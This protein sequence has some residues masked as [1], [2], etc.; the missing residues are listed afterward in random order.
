[1]LLGG[2]EWKDASAEADTWWLSRSSR[3]VVTVITSAAPDIPDTQVAWAADHFRELGAKVEGCQ[4]QSRRDA[5]DTHLLEQLAQAAA[6]YLCGGDPG[7]AQQALWDTPAAT[8]LLAAYRSGV[9]L[10]GSSA[11][12]MVLGAVCLVPGQDF[13]TRPGLGVFAAAV[14]PHWRGA[15]RRWRETAHRLSEDGE[16][17]AVDEST[18]ACWDGRTWSARGPGRALVVGRDGEFPVGMGR[19]SPPVE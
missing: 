5:A 13:A 8:A 4:I 3:P 12:A 15:N 18:G 11:G 7:A 19:P 9:P 16:V 2:N 6:I 10:A 14:V 17:I 1:M